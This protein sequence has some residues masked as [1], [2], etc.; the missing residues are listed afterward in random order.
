MSSLTGRIVRD[1]AELEALAPRWWELWR[2]SP[3]TTPFQSP[4]WLLPWWRSFAPG[5]LVTM[6]VERGE[7]LVGLA[8]FYREDGPWGRRLLPLGISVS[9][10]HDLLL[11]PEEEGAA[12]TILLELAAGQP[13]WD[14]WEFEEL[15]PGATALALPCPSGWQ[16]SVTAQSACPTLVFAPGELATSLPRTKRRKLNLARNRTA[17]RTS[18]EM[19]QADASSLD[20]ALG[21]LFRLHGSR[22]E[23]RG[24]TGVLAEER[25]RRFHREAAAALGAAGLLRLF[26]LAFEGRVVAA[27]YGFHDRARTYG[28]LTGFDPACEYESPGVLILAHVMEEAMR[29]GAR[30]FHFLR[31]QE[32]YKYDW[33]ALDRW[34]QR[35]S[36][37]RT[38]AQHAAA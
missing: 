11:A 19:R 10:Y 38:G 33:G 30:E 34:N 15:M 16:E 7:A 28:Y 32:P 24:E 4:A 1:V 6:V 21:H 37:R 8:P 29:E 31:G 3:D 12:W 5:D 25:V 18:V 13:D 22:W 23:E 17:R 14:L 36:L 27:F 20:D 26:T 9:D 2:R 35:R